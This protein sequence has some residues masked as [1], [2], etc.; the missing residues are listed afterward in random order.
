MALDRAVDDETF[1][2][3][4]NQDSRGQASPEIAAFLRSP[5]VIDRW[6]DSLLLLKRT[7]EIQLIGKKADLAAA[8]VSALSLGPAGKMVYLRELA[9]YEKW[10]SGVIRVL[11]K[12]LETRL[13]EAKRLRQTTRS[14]ATQTQL[15]R[16]R[17]LVL[18][19]RDHV[20]GDECDGEHCVADIALWKAVDSIWT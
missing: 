1:D 12:G 15:R 5:E 4:V 18:E 10:R 3:L 8:K 13:A 16:L 19:H 7:M 6:Y 2:K 17:E 14:D 20:C 11:A 9:A